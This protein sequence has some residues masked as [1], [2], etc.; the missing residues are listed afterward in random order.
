MLPKQCT[1]INYSCLYKHER[2]LSDLHRPLQVLAIMIYPGT[3]SL[4]IYEQFRTFQDVGIIFIQ[5]VLTCPWFSVVRIAE[6][7]SEQLCPLCVAIANAK[8]PSISCINYTITI[9]TII[10]QLIYYVIITEPF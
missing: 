8:P 6:T 4:I 5:F 2:G 9:Y 10:K 7:A 3:S 1:L